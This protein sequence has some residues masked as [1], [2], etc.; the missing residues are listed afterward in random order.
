MGLG[1]TM[2]AMAM[3][4]AALVAAVFVA[5]CVASSGGNDP[6]F[7]T[8]TSSDPASVSSF[9]ETPAPVR[10][11]SRT[12]PSLGTSIPV[13]AAPA[14]PAGAAAA[15]EASA[16]T[17]ASTP[18]SEG[19]R[20]GPLDVLSIQVFKVEDLTQTVQ[21]SESGRFGFPLVGEVQAGGRTVSEIEK[22]LAGK[23]EKDYVR[24]PQV[25][26]L[27]KEYNSHRITVEGAVK[28]PGVFPMQGPMSM[29]QAIA[30]GGGLDETSDGTVLLFRKVEGRTAVARFSMNDVRGQRTEDP[31]LQAGDIVMV[32]TS[33]MKVG[34]R[35]ILQAVPLARM[36][37]LL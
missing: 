16:V 17:A 24:N 12:S 33:D 6:A 29:L 11:S 27:V 36:F 9:T 32:P 18:G 37:L 34:M 28:K 31:A 5:G 8:G 20:V 4:G 14:G 3:R 25:T 2:A 35:Y 19:Y 26:V 15:S 7:T 23:L 10:S 21:V 1:R 13:E 22:D 30:S